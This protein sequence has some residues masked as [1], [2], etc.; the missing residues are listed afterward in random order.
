MDLFVKTR[1]LLQCEYISDIRTGANLKEARRMVASL[2]LSEY[3][4]SELRD[5]AQY[6]YGGSH[7][8]RQKEEVVALLK[9]Q[10][11]WY[12]SASVS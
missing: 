7:V 10:K 3:P 4:L 8:D 12:R 1:D 2:D 6:L 11:N 9:T 5:M